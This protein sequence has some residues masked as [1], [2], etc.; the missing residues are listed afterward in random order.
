MRHLIQMVRG[1]DARLPPGDQRITY[2]DARRP[3]GEKDM[4]ARTRKAGQSRRPPQMLGRHVTHKIMR[5][6]VCGRQPG[7]RT[8]TKT[9]KMVCP[10][11]ARP[12]EH[13]HT[14]EESGPD[15]E[16]FKNASEA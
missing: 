8:E 14:D 11:T 7:R 15:P 1:R 12:R 2:W 13:E 4:R 5:T 3:G 6:F 9:K 16:A 10:K